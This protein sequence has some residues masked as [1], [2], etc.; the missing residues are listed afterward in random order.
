MR[1]QGLPQDA[2][3]PALPKLRHEVAEHM[4]YNTIGKFK[5]KEDSA[6]GFVSFLMLFFLN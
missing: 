5:R 4:T 1:C 3:T 6:L 2:V